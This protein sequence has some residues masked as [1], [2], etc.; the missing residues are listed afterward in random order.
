MLVR[1]KQAERP[2][3]PRNIPIDAIYT[4]SDICIIRA[5]RNT[6]KQTS[7]AP[8]VLPFLLSMRGPNSETTSQ[9]ILNLPTFAQLRSNKKELP[10]TRSRLDMFVGRDCT[11]FEVL[12]QLFRDAWLTLHP[13]MYHP[14]CLC[15]RNT[16][17]DVSEWES[18]PK[19]ISTGKY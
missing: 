19:G 9:L 4:S 2:I 8:C 18:Q 1:Q 17:G 16:R 14:F 12:N 11:N 10:D 7:N 3:S 5:H 6:V 13:A 15:S